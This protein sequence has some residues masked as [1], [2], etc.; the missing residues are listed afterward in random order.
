MIPEGI[1]LFKNEITNSEL[2]DSLKKFSA[3]MELLGETTE[4][5]A[6][7]AALI[8]VVVEVFRETVVL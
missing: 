8:L 6:L 5:T 3:Y 7:T 1:L 2:L 4:G